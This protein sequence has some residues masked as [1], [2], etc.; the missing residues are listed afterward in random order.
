L[1]LAWATSLYLQSGKVEIQEYAKRFLNLSSVERIL[2]DPPCF[3]RAIWAISSTGTSSWFLIKVKWRRK[4]MESSCLI[5]ISTAWSTRK[6]FLLRYL[7][8]VTSSFMVFVLRANENEGV[9]KTMA[10]ENER[11]GISQHPMNL[12]RIALFWS[13]FQAL[14]KLSDKCDLVMRYIKG[15]G[16][17]IYAGTKC[18]EMP[19]PS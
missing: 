5:P 10:R 15:F 1:L 16:V 9:G 19:P 14:E 4:Q 11:L 13:V 8:Q 3:K 7:M 17:G 2:K 6:S 18:P 12:V